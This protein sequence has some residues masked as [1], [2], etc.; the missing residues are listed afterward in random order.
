MTPAELSRT[1]LRAVRRAVEEDALTA[2]VPERAAVERTRPG[3]TGDW[4]SNIALRLAKQAG[5]TPYEVAEVLKERLAGTPGIAAVDIT[6]PGFLSFTLAGE[7]QDQVVRELLEQGLVRDPR[8]PA[9]EPEAADVLRLGRDAAVWATLLPGP[10]LL[11]QHE[12]N[13]LFRVRYAY[14]RTRAL[15]RNASD[16]GFRGSYEIPTDAPELIGLLGGYAVELDAAV[17]L[18]APE[19]L[20][21]HLVAVADA[22]LRFQDTHPVLPLGDEKP[23]AAHRSRLAVAEAAGT[24][25]AGGLSQLGVSAPDHL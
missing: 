25:L 2:P 6:G 1:V 24:V 23:S 12:R 13:P 14:S 7:V 21:R 16:L 18:G 9:P 3:G 10:D 17:R 19:R 8:L 15:P 22:F 20:A 5:K 4:A 11:A